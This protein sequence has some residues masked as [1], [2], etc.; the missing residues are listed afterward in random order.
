MTS[1][2]SEDSAATEL[3]LPIELILEVINVL[4][5]KE[6]LTML[7]TCHRL[8][9]ITEPIFY[10]S[11]VLPRGDAI[12]QLIDTLGKRPDLATHVQSLEGYL[13]PTLIHL[14]QPWNR[15]DL[16]V[17]YKYAGPSEGTVFQECLARM[18]NATK[19]LRRICIRDLQLGLGFSTFDI[20]RRAVVPNVSLTHLSL[21][22]ISGSTFCRRS[23]R[24]IKDLLYYLLDLFRSQP[25]IE[26]LELP[27]FYTLDGLIGKLR[28]TDIPRLKSLTATF[29]DAWV[30]ARGRPVTTL[31]LLTA[32]NRAE[33]LADDWDNLLPVASQVTFLS[34][35]FGECVPE[36][37][38]ANLGHMAIHLRGLQAL[39]LEDMPSA[40]F[41][42][43]R[44]SPDATSLCAHAPHLAGLRKSAQ[45]QFHPG[46]YN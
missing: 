9:D 38:E 41:S 19:N 29:E 36:A 1:I 4:E 45:V 2:K 6:L 27:P 34:V 43:V 10:R 21:V 25:L 17:E 39:Y 14:E 3:E 23:M 40:Y 18:L 7:Q 11:I 30:L 28:A 20:I 13:T 44:N 16:R 35:F 31:S 46:G 15:N 24:G 33:Y 37:V 22:P 12:L 5:Q 42:K 26:T 8:H 32:P